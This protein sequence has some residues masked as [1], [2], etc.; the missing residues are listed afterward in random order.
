LWVVHV[1]T[2]SRS[3]IS[4]ASLISFCMAKVW[5]LHLIIGYVVAD[6]RLSFSSWL[7]AASAAASV[8]TTRRASAMENGLS[9]WS[10]AGLHPQFGRIDVARRAISYLHPRGSNPGKTSHTKAFHLTAGTD[11]WAPA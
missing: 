7:S 5:W 11:C 8:S 4:A 2:F 1:P 6:N 3:G 10:P 9:C